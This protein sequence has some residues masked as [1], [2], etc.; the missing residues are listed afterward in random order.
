[1]DIEL[2]S[3]LA[4]HTGP[5]LDVSKGI[6]KWLQKTNI[7]LPYGEEDSPNDML[8]NLHLAAKD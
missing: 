2:I 5:L 1:M 8:A 3:H 6:G 7:N 4:F